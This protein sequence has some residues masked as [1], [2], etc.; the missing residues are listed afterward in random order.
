MANVISVLQPGGTSGTSYNVR[1]TGIRHFNANGTA[2][3]QTPSEG[4][5]SVYNNTVKITCAQIDNLFAGLMF[6]AAIPANLAAN[7]S[8]QINSLSSAAITVHNGL[9]TAS[10]GNGEYLFVYDG[11]TFILLD[12]VKVTTSISGID[13]NN[14]DVPTSNAVV[15]Y[16]TTQLSNRW[17]YVI[18]PAQANQIPAGATYK[19]GTTTVNGT[20]AASSNTM[21]TIY[22]VKHDHDT[23]HSTSDAYDEWI[24]INT[25]GSTYVWEKIGNTDIDV[26]DIANN[27][28][29]NI[30]GSIAD[31]TIQTVDSASV[32]V[33]SHTHD[34]TGGQMTSTGNYTP[35]GTVNVGNDIAGTSYTPG[36]SISVGGTTGANYTPAGTVISTFAGSAQYIKVSGSQATITVS[37]TN[38]PTG[39]NTAAN[40]SVTWGTGTNYTKITPTV[41]ISGNT[42]TNLGNET[43]VDGSHTHTFSGS[44][45]SSSIS[46]SSFTVS[47]KDAMAVTITSTTASANDKTFQV[48]ISSATVT[49]QPVFAVVNNGSHTHVGTVAQQTLS[50]SISNTGTASSY[51]VSGEVLTL[52]PSSTP[53]SSVS[54]TFPATAVTIAT[55]GDHGHTVNRSTNAAISVT[56]GYVKLTASTPSHNHTLSGSVTPTI[57]VVGTIGTVNGHSHSVSF[58]SADVASVLTAT[59]S[60]IGLIVSVGTHTHTVS[61]LS[62]S[63][64]YTPSV[65]LTTSATSASGYV[66]ITPAGRVDSSF[67][68]TQTKLAFSGSQV[69]FAFNGASKQVS[70]VGTTVGTIGT[71]AIGNKTVSLTKTDKTLSH[72]L[73]S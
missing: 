66:N 37:T 27:I 71:T 18:C 32:N 50:G 59:A 14:Y 49:T 30:I 8:L 16:V 47:T 24:T 5:A 45:S 56:G 44:G 10:I 58:P 55:A 15:N 42:N 41:T 4:C 11:S 25:S 62:A 7:A 69:K 13:A 20:M 17:N 65:S 36:G 39:N 46:G 1:A 9:S 23:A 52:T 21:Y 22:L 64:T 34:F 2:T 68:G 72:S 54:V 63:T 33:G 43:E 51:S 67:S 26:S 28:A 70:V 29:T 40:C 61:S 35:E 73:K 19:S 60:Q 3:A 48:P 53:G 31:H 12:S 57:T 6:T 38:V